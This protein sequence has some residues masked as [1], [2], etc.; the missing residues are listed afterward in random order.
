[1]RAWLRPVMVLASAVL[2]MACD[3]LGPTPAP[4]AIPRVALPNGVTYLAPAG[5]QDAPLDALRAQLQQPIDEGQVSGDIAAAWS[6]LVALI[7]AHTLIG[8][9]TGQSTGSEATVAILIFDI[10]ATPSLDDTADAALALVDVM[11]SKQVT[12]RTR[13]ALPIG[14]AIRILSSGSPVGGSPTASIEYVIDLG[15][16]HALYLNGAAPVGDASFEPIMTAFAEGLS[17]S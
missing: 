10:P 12:S 2:L 11:P 1:M 13:I 6:R 5:W 16:G 14:P 8:A 3:A 15:N 4:T 9:V 7:D 17:K